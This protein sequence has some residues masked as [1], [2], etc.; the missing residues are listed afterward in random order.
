MN[1]KDRQKRRLAQR[2]EARRTK[3]LTETTEIEG[4][5]VPSGA[6]PANLDEQAPNNSYGPPYYYEDTPFTCIDCGREQIWTAEQQQWWYEVAKGNVNSRAVRCR[7][8][9]GERRAK[10][11]N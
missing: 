9:R 7:P 6:I 8:C 11:E 10:T 1:R 4:I 3:R 2:I 5:M